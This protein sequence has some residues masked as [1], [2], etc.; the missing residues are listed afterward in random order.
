MAVFKARLVIKTFTSIRERN[1]ISNK[2]N[3]SGKNFRFE[4]SLLQIMVC[5][6]T[7]TLLLLLLLLLL[8]F[9]AFM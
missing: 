6:I 5:V 3:T 2:Q 4:F 1:L 7:C 9:I 8:L